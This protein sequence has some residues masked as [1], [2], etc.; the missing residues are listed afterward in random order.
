MGKRNT[1]KINPLDNAEH[2]IDLLLSPSSR[3]EGP[4]EDEAEDRVPEAPLLEAAAEA[5]SQEAETQ[6]V[7]YRLPKRLYLRLK[8][9][10]A[11]EGMDMQEIVVDA[12]LR[13]LQ[14]L[15]DE[16]GGPYLPD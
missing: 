16:R 13:E 15:E 9:A 5:P 7:N 6:K 4:S 1:M 3:S 14:R 11:L 12:L 10:S 8:V 2:A